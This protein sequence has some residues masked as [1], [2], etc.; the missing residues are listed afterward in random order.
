MKR[1]C[2]RSR[3]G[4][5]ALA[6]IGLGF[7]LGLM[8]QALLFPLLSIAVGA[9]DSAA[10]ATAFAIA[11]VATTV[12]VRALFGLIDHQYELARLKRAESLARRLAT[13]RL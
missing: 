13:G 6:S 12:I 9:F 1:P 11:S 3:P 10:I 7:V 4:T 5:E 2:P 8:L